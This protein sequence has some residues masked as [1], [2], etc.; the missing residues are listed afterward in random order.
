MLS[1]NVFSALVS[2]AFDDVSAARRLHAFTEAVNLA[3][4]TLFGLVSSFHI[5]LL[6]IRS[7]KTNRIPSYYKEI[8][9]F[10]QAIMT[11]S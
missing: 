6:R 10:R 7:I 1:G 5:M 2:A 3:S 9:K 8:L 4:L 11:R